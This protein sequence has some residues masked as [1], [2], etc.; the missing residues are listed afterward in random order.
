M[1]L[2]NI[3]NIGLYR[4][5]SKN[6]LVSLL[7]MIVWAAQTSVAIEYISRSR[8]T[9]AQRKKHWKIWKSEK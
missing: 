1:L 7:C 4:N 8:F 9:V 5:H 3:Y 6:D 2:Y